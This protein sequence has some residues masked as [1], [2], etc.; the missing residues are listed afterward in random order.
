M[1]GI[2]ILYINKQ[3]YYETITYDLSF[4]DFISFL[5]KTCKYNHFYE[6]S[7]IAE[8]LPSL[9]IF[10][11][12]KNLAGYQNLFPPTYITQQRC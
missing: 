10:L 5:Y 8:K 1:W 11:F 4:E 12:Q 6:K 9:I 2:S 7:K 3:I